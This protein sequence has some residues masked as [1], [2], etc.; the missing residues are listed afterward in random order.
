[1]RIVRFCVRLLLFF[2]DRAY[3]AASNVA[4]ALVQIWANKIRSLLTV[5]GIIIAVTSIITV[6]TLVEGFGNYVTNFLRGL[7]TNMMVVYP[8]RVRGPRGEYLR[9]AEMT[10]EDVRAVDAYAKAIRRT[11][12]VVYTR[13][14]VEYGRQQLPGMDLRCTNEFFQPIRNFYVDAGRFFGA[15]DVET[16]AP[17]CVLGREVLRKLECDESL[18]GDYVHIDSQRFRV[19]GLLQAKGSFMG[20]NQDEMIVI[21]WTTGLKMY[22]YARKYLAFYVEAMDESQ[23]SE[24]EGQLARLLRQRHGLKPGQPNDFGVFK[25][26]EILKEFKQIRLIATSVLAGIVSISLLVGGIGIMNV[27]LVSVTERTREIGLRKSVGARR[28]DILTQF[29]TEAAVLSTVGGAIGIALGYGAC[30][31]AALHP[32]MVEVNV[33]IWSVALALGFSAAVGIFFG[34]IPAFKAA[35]IHPIDALRHE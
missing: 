28:R 3:A 30:Y 25:Q 27:M 5:L 16:A 17:V 29:L 6:V 32:S 34:I 15:V 23:I 12:P 7:G 2:P 21:P 19:V 11:S 22:P 33:P 24:A 4:T 35:I 13:A 8:E 9:P 10:I 26:D 31:L 18:V 1:M 14:T 20:D